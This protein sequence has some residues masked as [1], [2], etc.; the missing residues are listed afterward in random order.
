MEK[1]KNSKYWGYMELNEAVRDKLQPN[2]GVG[3]EII[4]LINEHI[5]SQSSWYNW[6]AYS[7]TGGLTV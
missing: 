3:R 1:D 2:I 4:L 7:I 5:V 6:G